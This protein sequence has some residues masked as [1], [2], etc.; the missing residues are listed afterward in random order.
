MTIVRVSADSPLKNDLKLGDCILKVNG[1]LINQP[2]DLLR[3]VMMSP[4]KVL[5]TVES[6]N[7]KV[8]HI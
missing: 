2:G 1:S 5:F 7:K 3:A 8:Q 6:N 4:E